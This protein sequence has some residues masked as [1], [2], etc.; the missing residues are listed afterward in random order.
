MKKKLGSVCVYCGSSV[1]ANREYARAAQ[2][3]GCLF[4]ERGITLVYGGGS[5]GLMGVI[6]DAA[7]AA[8]GRVIGVIP[9]GLRTRELA[10]EGLSEMVAVDSMHARKQIMVD[11]SDAFIA[12]PGGIGTLDELFEAFTWLQLG[13]HDKPVGMLNVSGYYDSL[14][15]FLQ[16]MGEEKFLKRAH[17]EC[18]MVD[19]DASRLLD[20]LA[21]SAA[22][23]GGKWVG[24]QS[25]I[26]P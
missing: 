2:E 25:K 5:I 7:L 14:I 23:A 17:L 13:I 12:L 1:G 19:D 18:L 20:R 26:A 24:K 11:R 22:P 16:R 3:L 9:Q 4:A 21:A 6:A 8:G 15:Q 10:H